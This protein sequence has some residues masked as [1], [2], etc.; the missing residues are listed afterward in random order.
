MNPVS[1]GNS[2]VNAGNPRGPEFEE[3]EQNELKDKGGYPPPT[4]FKIIMVYRK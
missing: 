4:I 1:C 3:E 2:D